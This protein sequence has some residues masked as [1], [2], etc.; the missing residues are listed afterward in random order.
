MQFLMKRLCCAAALLL[1][2]APL[3]L[4]QRLSFSTNLSDYLLLGTLNL[5]GEYAIVQHWSAGTVVKYNPWTFF[6]GHPD[7]QMQLRQL[8]FAESARWWPWHTYSGWW[9]EAGIQYQQYSR[10][11]I[12]GKITEEGDAYGL[13]VGA[14]YMTMLHRNWNLEFG[15]GL[16]AGRTKYTRYSCPKCGKLLEEG[17]RFFAWPNEVILS[18]VYIF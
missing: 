9:A 18:L 14:G 6:P 10:G 17:E 2:A 8:C 15:A 3:C 12:W 5:R 1:L 13:R 16:W 7:K 11:G 4:A